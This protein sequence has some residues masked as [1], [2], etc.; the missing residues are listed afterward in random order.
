[1][2]FAGFTAVLAKFGMNGISGELGLAVRTVVILPLVLAFAYL[3]VSRSALASLV[4]KS[5]RW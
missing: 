3:N 2:I 4:C 5:G 1:M